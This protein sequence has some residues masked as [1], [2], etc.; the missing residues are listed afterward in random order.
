MPLPPE[1]DILIVGINFCKVPGTDI[2]DTMTDKYAR[3]AEIDDDFGK[4]SDSIAYPVPQLKGRS[5]VGDRS[6]YNLKGFQSVASSSS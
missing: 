2:M 6:C 3:S 4:R 1:A 5:D